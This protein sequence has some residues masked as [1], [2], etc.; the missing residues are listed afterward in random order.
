MKALIQRVSHGSVSIAGENPRTISHGLVVLL[1]ITHKDAEKEVQWMVEKILNLR[2]FSRS[3]KTEPG[4]SDFDLSVQDSQ[5]ELLIVSQFTLYADVRKG[6]RP[7][8]SQ[9]AP[10]DQAKQVYDQFVQILKQRYPRVETGEFG[11]SMQ[12]DIRNEGPVTIWL[13]I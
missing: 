10:P 8:F 13:E 7:D 5:G 12:V 9:A 6:R 1:G 4:Q 11:A 3:L 2:V